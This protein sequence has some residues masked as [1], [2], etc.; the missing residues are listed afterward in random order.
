MEMSQNTPKRRRKALPQSMNDEEFFKLIQKLNDKKKNHK[1]YKV[2]FLLGYESGLRI[3]EVRNLLPADI[4]II[5]KTIF[6]R[7]GKNSKDRVVPLPKTW[8]SWMLKE[9]QI[10]LSIRS[11]QRKFK[12]CCAKAG[13][14]PIYH[15]HSLRHSFATNCLERGMPINQVQ[16]LL[17][18]SSV[19]V[20]NIYVQARPSQALEK[21][22]EVF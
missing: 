10:K 2:A 17:G 5:A 21:Y 12:D 16:I 9:I 15:F 11:L 18:H 13:L 3:S 19:A 22:Q 20:T 6:I 8:K 4:D 1:A 7:M 14:N